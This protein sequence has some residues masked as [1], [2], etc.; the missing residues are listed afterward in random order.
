MTPKTLLECINKNKIKKIK[1]IVVMYMGGYPENVIE[2][3]RIKKKFRCCLIE[4]ACHSLGAE[5]TYKRKNFYI[6][7]CSHSDIAT[8]SLHPVKT[9]TTGEGGVVTTNNKLFAERIKS[10]RSHGIARKK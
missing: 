10:L 3:Y 5:Y 4:D 9:I 7:S 1:A 8:F 6:G 2:F